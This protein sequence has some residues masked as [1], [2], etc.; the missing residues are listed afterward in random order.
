MKYHNDSKE[1]LFCSSLSLIST[2]ENLYYYYAFFLTN[3]YG[4]VDKHGNVFG[5]GVFGLTEPVRINESAKFYVYD[6]S[7]DT[8]EE[9]DFEKLK[10]MRKCGL[11][12]YPVSHP[13]VNKFITRE[14]FDG[15]LKMEICKITNDAQGYAEEL[16]RLIKYKFKMEDL[17]YAKMTNT[18]YEVLGYHFRLDNDG[19]VLLKK[20][21]DEIITIIPSITGVFGLELDGTSKPFHR[22]NCPMMKVFNFSEITDL[23]YLFSDTDFIYLDLSDFNTNYAENL[24][25]MFSES[26]LLY[27][28]FDFMKYNFKNVRNVV[29]MF[30][31]CENLRE[32]DL[33]FINLEGMPEGALLKVKFLEPVEPDVGDGYYTYDM[34]D[35]SNADLNLICEN[36]EYNEYEKMVMRSFFADACEVLCEIS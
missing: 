27:V 16:D 1:D 36:W 18:D 10:L 7:D 25:G 11:L 32:M 14:E 30:A 20:V 29:G 2:E 8:L 12:P 17:I 23:S 5:K 9:I 35:T 13:Y 34:F 19:N 15:L 22:N 26:K 21:P 31:F 3:S 28:T 33:S 24:T 6:F 4:I